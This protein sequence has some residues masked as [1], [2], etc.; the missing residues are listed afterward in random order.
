MQVTTQEKYAFVVGSLW[1]RM[2]TNIISSDTVAE[3]EYKEKMYRHK[4]ECDL[5]G[6]VPIYKSNRLVGYKN[7]DENEIPSDTMLGVKNND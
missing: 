6:I 3:V 4:Y 5:L 2:P 7:K 1:A